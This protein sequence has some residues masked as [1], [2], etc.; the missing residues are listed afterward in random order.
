MKQDYTQWLLT[1]AMEYADKTEIV[2]FSDKIADLSISILNHWHETSLSIRLEI[3]GKLATLASKMNLYSVGLS[4]DDISDKEE[5]NA[6]LDASKKCTACLIG[7]VGILQAEVKALI[8]LE[9]T[10]VTTANNDPLL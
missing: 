8:E 10:G 7:A 6:Y 3:T 5:I 4:M 2:G 1:T 9:K